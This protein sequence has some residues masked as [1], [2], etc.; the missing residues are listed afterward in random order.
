MEELSETKQVKDNLQLL[1]LMLQDA[2]SAPSLYKPTG[3]WAEY[4]K[5][6]LPELR[7]L[8]LQDFRRRKN[9]VLSM[10]GATDL[11][12]IS[13][14]LSYLPQWD[15]I[16]RRIK[17]I[18]SFLKLSVKTRLFGKLIRYLSSTYFG[19]R[20]EDVRL[21]LYEFAKCYGEKNGAKPLV[22][23]K[24][25]TVGN[26]EDVFSI[27]RNTYTT[28]IL[29]YYIQYAY[30]CKYMNFDF[31][32][33]MLEIGSGSGKQIEVIRKLH[34]HLCFYI[35]DLPLQLYVCEQYLSALFPD[36]VVSYAQTR[37]MKSIPEPDQGKIFFFGNWKLPELTNLKYDL[38]WNSAGFQEIEPEIVLNYLKYV[39]LQTKNY[40]FLNAVME[41]KGILTTL[42]HYK[43]GFVN[44]H[45]K[46]LSRAVRLPITRSNYSF[47][48]W[49]RK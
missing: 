42:E 4:E 10:F 32:N 44:F 16:S 7:T 23:L 49:I 41:G 36:S 25:S 6:F 43:N 17:I 24:A 40:I 8:G 47:S 11:L 9:S 37:T 31:I 22:E 5:I 29:N 48:F 35:F 28:S 39:N 20:L 15:R 33:A 46:D 30:C 2:R 27:N 12:P 19:M 21:L 26:P 14:S 18:R 45:L 13:E 3:Y 1:E 34:P 38:F